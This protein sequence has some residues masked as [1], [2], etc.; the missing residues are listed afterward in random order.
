M[1]NK[2]NDDDEFEG[3]RPGD[4]DDVF[5]LDDE[6]FDIETDNPNDDGYLDDEETDYE[7]YIYD[8]TENSDN[9]ELIETSD[10]EPKE[11]LIEDIIDTETAKKSEEPNTDE[12][13]I[14]F[15]KNKF[16]NSKINNEDD[17]LDVL[18]DLKSTAFDNDIDI[19]SVEI[20]KDRTMEY[21]N[22]KG[23]IPVD[24]PKAINY[25]FS[26]EDDVQIEPE[27][28]QIEE[29]DISSETEETSEDTLS[30][31]K[32][33][34]TEEGPTNVKE[35][36]S[37]PD[38]PEEFVEQSDPSIKHIRPLKMEEI[39]E[40][41]NGVTDN[42]V[43]DEV[44]KLIDDEINNKSN[45]SENEAS[46]ETINTDD[47]I[48]DEIKN[49]VDEEIEEKEKPISEEEIP[50]EIKEIVDEEIEGNLKPMSEEEIPDE[51][52]EIVNDIKDEDIP[53]IETPSDRKAKEKE[54][55]Q[56]AK[57]TKS[58]KDY[59]EFMVDSFK[60]SVKKIY[61]R[62]NEN[63]L[64]NYIKDFAD[65]EN[66]EVIKDIYIQ[67]FVKYEMFIKFN[68]NPEAKQ[69][70]WVLSVGEFADMIEGLKHSGNIKSEIVPDDHGVSS[71]IV[72]DENIESIRS[73]K[74]QQNDKY[75]EYKLDRTIFDISE[76]EDEANC[77]IFDDK[78]TLHKDFYESEFYKIHKEVM[79]SDRFADMSKVSATV[80][81]N[82]KTSY[83][84]VIDYSTG[85]RVYCIDPSDTDQFHLNPMLINRN[86]P[87]SFKNVKGV[88]IRILYK[89]DCKNCEFAVISSLKKIIGFKYIKDRYKISLNRNYTIGYTTEPKFIDMFNSGD[90]DSHS[91]ENCT[92]AHEKPFNL[93][94]GIIILDRKSDNDRRAIRRNQIKRDLGHFEKVSVEDYNIQFV[95]SANII[96]ND[97]RL[98]NPTLPAEE[99]YVEYLITQYNECNP[100]IINDGLN[101]ITACIIKEHMRNY[102]AG[103]GYSI[104]FEY[105]RDS[106]LS[107]AIIAMLDERDGVS[108]TLG[109][110]PNIFDVDGQ[111]ILPQS[112]LKLDGVFPFEKGRIDK[113]FFSPI[114]IQRKYPRELW[115][116]YDLSTR[117]G[118]IEF[119]R[120]RGFEEFIHLKP[121]QFDIEPWALNAIYSS[122]MIRNITRVS[123][124]MLS[125]RNSE[126]T[127]AMLF[128]QSE[129]EYIKSMG[130]NKIGS[131]Q[132]FLFAAM[133]YIL[134][135][136]STSNN[137]RR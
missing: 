12:I 33:V 77:S 80:I 135:Q 94:I 115:Q 27:S 100:V 44:T 82:E 61:D 128:K 75:S 49:I 16:I 9:D 134:D 5:E 120:S 54:A 81:I 121:V 78:K 137:E 95:L 130:N 69:H 67:N 97:L 85:V 79:T 10:E 37:G 118:R 96:K 122:E 15:I 86:V 83:I 129:L 64:L 58:E 55:E 65:K 70:L 124:E 14:E 21:L 2:H 106:L 38:I 112:R 131:F 91:P 68:E 104:S 92:T 34:Y 113:R 110:K 18:S 117:D 35:L 52:K 109:S 60:T 88:K 102:D 93:Q 71:D 40:V 22:E 31:A 45:P 73:H 59:N 123:M 24:D 66:K 98:R 11:E 101:V 19:P 108:P 50:D 125:D 20:M 126:D 133:D 46:E 56:N 63:D 72:P 25:I 111:F 8:E 87:F 132:K 116:N 127:E 36:P 114:T 42:N 74:R 7:D 84:P 136:Y 119:I 48:P 76:D 39:K 107:P 17:L 103:T 6:G 90:P 57:E 3:I 23:Y 1:V 28:E 32:P 89:D 30:V 51:I 105:D 29:T 99:R 41:I 53:N 47:D 26:N 43:P 13:S 62:Y 4:I